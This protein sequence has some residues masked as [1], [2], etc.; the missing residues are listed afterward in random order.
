MIPD[1]TCD[2][3]NQS[4]SLNLKLKSLC[5]EFSCQ[6]IFKTN[7]N[8]GARGYLYRKLVFCFRFF[9]TLFPDE[10]KDIEINKIAIFIFGFMEN[11]F[12]TLP[13]GTLM[14]KTVNCTIFIF[15][16]VNNN[17]LILLIY[18]FIQL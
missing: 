13:R 17:L 5:I 15:P 16:S 12:F 4:L 11:L 2:G 8:A 9:Q 6:L 7:K 10:E 14:K 1:G 3:E 18:L